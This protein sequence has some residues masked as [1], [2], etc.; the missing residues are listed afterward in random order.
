MK[1]IL[2]FR[3]WTG[4]VFAVLIQSPALF[5]NFRGIPCREV[6]KVEIAIGPTP[7]NRN[8]EGYWY[9]HSVPVVK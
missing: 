8:G 3:L 9:P 6:E 4:V 7:T 5:I 2:N 1:K